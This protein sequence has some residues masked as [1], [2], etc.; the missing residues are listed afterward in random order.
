VQLLPEL[1]LG[2]LSQ[3]LFLLKQVN[4]TLLLGVEVV[5][6]CISLK[7]TTLFTLL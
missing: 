7:V 5:A 4:E 1:L 2:L 6:V 3:L